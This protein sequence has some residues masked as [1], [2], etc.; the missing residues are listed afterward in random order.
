MR[1]AL[2]EVNEMESILFSFRRDDAT[3]NL[4]IEGNQRKMHRVKKVNE[5]RLFCPLNISL[6]H[7]DLVLLLFRFNLHR[8]QGA[9]FR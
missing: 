7:C 3:Q 9:N 5:F 8:T 6:F 1:T 4:I 2:K